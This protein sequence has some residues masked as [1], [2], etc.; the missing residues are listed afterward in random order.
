MGGGVRDFDFGLVM[1]LYDSGN[2]DISHAYLNPPRSPPPDT[3]FFPI[4]QPSTSTSHKHKPS[5]TNTTY[6][7]PTL[8]N[9]PYYQDATLQ[10][11]HL[12]H[13]LR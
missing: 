10:L 8:P 12:L 2:P 7:E 9:P 6:Q 5:I 1:G 4:Y 11:C 13:L 3:S